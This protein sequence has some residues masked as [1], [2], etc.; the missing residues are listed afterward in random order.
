MRTLDSRLGFRNVI[1]TSVAL[2]ASAALGCGSGADDAG[3]PTIFRGSVDTQG[4]AGHDTATG[5]TGGNSSSVGVGGGGISSGGAAGGGI[6]SGGAAGRGNSSGG[7]AG[8]GNSSGGGGGQRRPW[9]NDVRRW[10]WRQRRELGNQQGNGGA[11]AVESAS[12]GFRRAERRHVG[13]W[14]NVTPPESA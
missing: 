7:A 10:W 3:D 5:G 8:A 1:I 11:R 2:A 9:W 13:Q 14:E 6:S 12:Q 4:G